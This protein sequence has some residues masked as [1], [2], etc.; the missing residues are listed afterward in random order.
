MLVDPCA[1]S[2]QTHAEPVL[3]VWGHGHR[4]GSSVPQSPVIRLGSWGRDQAE[5][6]LS[7]GMD[8]NGKPEGVRDLDIWGHLAPL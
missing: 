6:Q 3:C 1:F 5:G 2:A 8:E 7:R 4:T